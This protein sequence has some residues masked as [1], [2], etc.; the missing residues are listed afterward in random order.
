MQNLIRRF[1][2]V[3]HSWISLFE[4]AVVCAWAYVFFEW[5]FIVTKPSFFSAVPMGQKVRVL[6][7]SAALLGVLVLLSLA[8]LYLIAR[9]FRNQ[10]VDRV[11]RGLGA[12]VLALILASLSLLLF[13]NF[14]YTV[15]GFG[16]ISTAGLTVLPYLIGFLLLIG[17]F[18][19]DVKKFLSALDRWLEPRAWRTYFNLG[20]AILLAAVLVLSYQQPHRTAQASLLAEEGEGRKTPNI[21]L[22]TADGLD[23]DHMSLYGYE[24]ETTPNIKALAED[25]LLALN[26]FNNSGNTMGSVVSMYTGKYPTTTRALYAPDILKGEDAYQH[27]PNILRQL[28]YYNVQYTYP[29]HADAYVRNVLEGFDEANGKTQQQNVFL[30][31]LN[32]YLST[33]TAYFQYEV[34][35]RLIDRL[36][37]ITFI[38]RMLT[39]Q[40]ILFGTTQIFNDPEK[41]DKV[42]RA[43]NNSSQPV[44][45]HIHW[46]GTHGPLREPK[47]RTFSAGKSIEAQEP[48]DV[49]IYDDS[50]LD[51][52]DAIAHITDDLKEMGIYDKTILIISSDHSQNNGTLKRIPLLIHFPEGQHRSELRSSVQ[53]IDLPPTLLDYLGLRQ[54]EWMKGVSLLKGEPGERPIFA[55]GVGTTIKLDKREVVTDL[56]KPPFYQFGFMS[57]AYCGMW[58]ELDLTSYQW[59]SGE[60]PGAVN[61]CPDHPTDETVLGWMRDRLA[62]DGFDVS[63]LNEVST[64]G[65]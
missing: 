27:L 23:A 47:N 60:V 64:D 12:L 30:N 20:I 54:P 46:M 59:R 29:H 1:L 36:R 41:I 34:A 3:K 63:P 33:D 56:L 35:N 8:G 45:A 61:A 44:F 7:F 38:K 24:R 13:D 62:V 16:I 14:T 17:Y 40:E 55:V 43:L 57:V 6:L 10:P 4:G 11:L 5:L 48:W 15:F 42:F 9:V 22:I 18:F 28:G 21:L 25:S 32:R 19:M 51:F 65:Q 39:Q 53:I 2:T 31:K 26:A 52:D 49:D 50:I 37:H 58:Y